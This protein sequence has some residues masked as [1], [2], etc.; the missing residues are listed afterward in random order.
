MNGFLYKNK[1]YQKGQSS[2]GAELSKIVDNP[3]LLE[4]GRRMKAA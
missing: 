2:G 1:R 3:Y 4:L